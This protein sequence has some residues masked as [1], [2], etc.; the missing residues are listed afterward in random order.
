MLAEGV[1]TDAGLR[2]N[3]LVKDFLKGDETKYGKPEPSEVC[4]RNRFG[5]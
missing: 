5:P 3:K 4:Q 2:L 1:N